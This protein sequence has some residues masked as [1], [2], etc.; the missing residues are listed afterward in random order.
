[1]AG[2]FKLKNHVFPKFKTQSFTATITALTLM[3]SL[4]ALPRVGAESL[5]PTP[6]PATSAQPFERRLVINIPSRTLWVYQG[7]KILRYF[8]VGVGRPGFM[9]PIGKYSIIS[10]VIDPGWENPYLPKGKVRLAPGEENP[11][12]TRWMGFYQKAGGEYGMHGTDNPASIGKFSSHGCVRMR[13]RDAEALFELIDLGTPVEVVYQ[14]VLIRKQGSSIRVI[15][16]ADRFAKG[17]PTP[18]QVKANILKQFPE[19]QVDLQKL[20]TA[21]SQPVERPIDVGALPDEDILQMQI[22]QP[23]VQRQTKLGKTLSEDEPLSEIPRKIFP[24]PK[25]YNP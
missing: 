17:M 6:K 2:L 23:P 12:G 25:L 13:I 11:L 21:L 4:Y 7:N 14:P 8:P 1:M 24:E 9:T 15:V 10:K 3:A 5:P 22:A 20:Q 18:A 16:Y 19:A